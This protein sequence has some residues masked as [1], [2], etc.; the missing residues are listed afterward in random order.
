MKYLD[1]TG[2]TTFWGK[3]KNYIDGKALSDTDKNKLDGNIVATLDNFTHN[4]DN[5]ELYY[6]AYYSENPDQL[7]NNENITINAAT[8]D[9]AGVMSASHVST[10]ESHTAA[11]SEIREQ[12][13]NIATGGTVDL[14]AYVKKAGDTMTGSLILQ[15]TQGGMHQS[16]LINDSEGI[17]EVSL[18][19]I[20]G[21]VLDGCNGNAISIYHSE[22]TN[23]TNTIF[24]DSNYSTPFVVTN[25]SSDGA[26][27]VLINGISSDTSLPIQYQALRNTYQYNTKVH[28]HGFGIYATR[29]DNSGN[30]TE[31]DAK[32]AFYGDT[33]VTF[34]AV[35][36]AVASEFGIKIENGGSANTYW[37]TDGS[38]QE[39]TAITSDE[40]SAL[41]N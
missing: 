5:V 16:L 2:L 30:I 8:I 41:F 33:S 29:T 26:R 15:P 25:E 1:L 34:Y 11:I 39:I 35:G 22:H 40:I 27:Y 9:A 14:S 3:V 24:G 32:R 36:S 21:L 20:D 17:N 31:E 18:D 19:V 28:T 37:A 4:T 10:L 23:D 38:Q 12:M 7:L 6:S 13:D